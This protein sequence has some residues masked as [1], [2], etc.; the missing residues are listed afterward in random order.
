MKTVHL[1]GN[2]HLDP[3]WLWQRSDGTDSALATARSACD[4]LDEYPEFVF[5][6]SGRWF[7]EQ[8]ERLDPALFERV[9]KFVAAGRWQPVGGMVIQPDCNLPS[10]E[11]MARQLAAGQAY[12]RRAFGAP[13]TI[14]YNVDSFGHNAYLPRR[15]R[16]AGIDSY[17]FMRP[18]P[19]EKALPANLFRWRSPDGAEVT[20]FRIAG[21]YCTWTADLREN[22]EAALAAMPEGL[23]HTMCFFGVGDHGGGPTK[24]QIEW[25]LAHRSDFPGARLVF[26]HPRAYFDAVAPARNR[27]PVVE[28]ELQHHAIGCYAVERRIKVAMGR[29]E[30]RLV[31][32]EETLKALPRAAAPDA[33]ADL[34][35]AWNAVLFNQFHD[36]Y[37]GTCL[38]EASD[39]VTGELVAAAAEADRLITETTR[40]ALRAEARPGQ[41]R[42]VLFNPSPQVF[43]GCV[44]HE[45]FGAPAP[46]ALVDERGVMVPSQTIE[47]RPKSD[48]IRRLLFKVSIPPRSWRVLRV[49]PAEAATVPAAAPER[50]SNAG[51]L[52]P[53]LSR[54]AIRLAGWTIAL[55]VCDD[56][57]DTWSHSTGNRFAGPV[58]GRFEWQDGWTPVESGPIRTAM[59]SRAA[60]GRSEAWC[61]AMTIAD[62]PMLRLRLSVGW[63]ESQRLLRLRLAAPGTLASRQDLVSGG[64]LA[65]ALDGAEYPLGGALVVQ[66]LDDGTAGQD[67]PWHTMAVVAP[68]IFS[69]SADPEGI[70]LTLLRSPFAAWHDPYPAAERPDYPVTDQGRH[71]FE[72]VLWPGC[73]ADL[74]GPSRLAQE[75]LAPPITWDLTG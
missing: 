62:E 15:L 39:A 24:A 9:R 20:T 68:D 2:A 18:G 17:V 50:R 35:R 13:T 44:A 19:H 40:R 4:R 8:V 10:A 74:A 70:S 59:R 22:I 26:S 31:Q 12:F 56:P 73:P 54:D 55:E 33:A 75:M 7:H 48:W 61:R 38:P 69:V 66:S 45:P 52:A 65:R 58:L 27:L 1:I 64:P 34:E 32:A 6:C 71:E 43:D 63:A 23:E 25:L 49:T 46:C 3:V 60:F 11:S 57:T 67:R 29:A 51:G 30:S 53:D 16:E 14:G 21:G 72:I 36:I 5:T 42:I 28:G 41:H 47:S 37:G